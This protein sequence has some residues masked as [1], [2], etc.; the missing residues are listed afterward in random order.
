MGWVIC[1]GHFIGIGMGMVVGR[2]GEIEHIDVFTG[3]FD[4]GGRS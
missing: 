3:Q 2:A 4:D 1:N